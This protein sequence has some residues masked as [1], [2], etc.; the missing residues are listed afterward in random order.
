MRISRDWLQTFFDTP[1]PEASVLSEALTFHVFEIDGIDAHG[2]DSILDVKVTPNRG[3]DCLSYRGIAKELSAILKLPLTNDPFA[4]APTLEPKTNTTAVTIQRTDLCKRYIAGHIKGVKVGESPAWLKTALEAMGQRSVNNVVD[5]TN[6]VMFHT[7]QPLHAFDAGKL[8][9]K[10][11]AYAIDVRPARAGETMHALDGKEYTL[12]ESVLVIADA[13]A[14]TAVGIAGVKGGTPA[15]ITADT[16][17][18]IIESANF[19]GVSV[20]KTA[21]T[22][23]L[24]TDASSRFEQSM[25]PEL[26]GYGMQSVVE[27]I[28]KLAGGEV[29]G[30]VD[31]YPT[32]QTQ[33]SVSIPLSKIN[34]ILGT[35]L[36]GAEVADVFLRLGFAYKEEHEVFEVIPPFERLDLTIREDV[37][38]EVARII[39]YDKIL[40]AP[41]S[42]FPKPVEVNSQFYWGE[43][44]REFLLNQGFSEVFTSVF[45]ETGER[46]VLNK[47]DGV[48]P[49]LRASLTEGLEDALS[50]N[51]R[52]KELLGLMQVKLFE[53]GTVWKDGKEE[54]V[55][56][57][58]VEKVKKHKTKEDYKAELDAFIATISKTPNT[59]EQLPL[60]V[61]EKFQPFSKYP[62]IVRDIAL[63]TP[64]GTLAE[65]VEKMIRNEAGELCVRIDL[66]D[67]F[68][69][70][71]KISLAYRL[72]FQSFERTL[73]EVE[74]NAVMEKLSTALSAKGFEIR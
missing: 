65:D 72:I 61:S 47:V 57:I 18:I 49:Y 73:T 7:G 8:T 14:N 3:H 30:F 43:A 28:Q 4:K 67:R 22:L 36:T 20:R 70:E 40:P 32:P 54:I 66:F 2:S 35:S 60:S 44:V 29:I 9:E 26:A 50:R 16:T 59:Y 39:G 56:E 45:T 10:D 46:V 21:A 25:S 55:V 58:A 15:S 41:L 51:V 34:T 19:D 74:A 48:R 69:K 33:A 1:L 42:A 71:G 13:H 52:T 12:S 17:D 11:G 63:W 23:K 6:Y 31:I 38:E 68:E 62:Y 53:I 27:L 5:A 64:A 24:R 37:V